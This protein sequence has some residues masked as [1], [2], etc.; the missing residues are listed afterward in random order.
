MKTSMMLVTFVYSSMVPVLPILPWGSRES[1]AQE[2]PQDLLS[3]L[4]E[5]GLKEEICKV[6]FEDL[7][8]G[9]VVPDTRDIHVRRP[10]VVEESGKAWH[11]LLD[12]LVGS[13]L[14]FLNFPRASVV[15]LATANEH[16]DGQ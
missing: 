14:W 16:P 13:Q 12:D 2:L 1:G 7:P 3:L 15:L 10:M 6:S 4:T 9:S 11:G 8:K 5:A